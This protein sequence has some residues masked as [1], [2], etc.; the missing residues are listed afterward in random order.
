MSLLGV[1]ELG[2][3]LVNL[4][5]AG[6]LF[7]RGRKS[8]GGP[9][10][11]VFIL[12]TALWGFCLFAYDTRTFGAPE[13][14]LDWVFVT[15]YSVIGSVFL[16]SVTFPKKTQSSLVFPLVVYC[17]GL[18][19]TIYGFLFSNLFVAGVT[20][21]PE[22]TEAVMTK[23]YT[24]Y[25]IAAAA[26]AVFTFRNIAYSYMSTEGIT[27]LQLKYIL[28]ALLVEYLVIFTTDVF[29]PVVFGET[30][31]FGI[32]AASSL[33]FIAVVLYVMLRSRFMGI[34]FI[35]GKV[36]YFTSLLL[37]VLVFVVIGMLL[38]VYLFSGVG[39]TAVLVFLLLYSFACAV[40][41]LNVQDRIKEI[42]EARFVY[43]KFNPFSALA[44][45]S[46]KVNNLY[47]FQQILA[48]ASKVV[49]KA[50]APEYV[51]TMVFCR[52]LAKYTA[53]AVG[54]PPKRLLSAIKR[55]FPTFD[56]LSTHSQEPIIRDELAI[57]INGGKVEQVEVAKKTLSLMD[58]YGISVIIPFGEGVELKGL[59]CLGEL[60]D[61]Q[62]VTEEDVS[63]VHGLVQVLSVSLGRAMLY[64]ELLNFNESLKTEVNLA[65]G[66]LK[67]KVQQLKVAKERE[68]EI[69]EI[70]GHELKNPAAIAKLSI[71]SLIEQL[72]SG[73]VVGRRTLQD[74]LNYAFSAVD[75]QYRL[76]QRFLSAARL[77][78]GAF[79]TVP[80]MIDL[81]E[82][83]LQCL[84]SL[85]L[86]AKE[87]GLYLKL[88]SKKAVLINADKDALQQVIYNILDNAIK[89]T[90]SGGVSI[91]LRSD[92]NEVSCQI[93]DTGIGIQSEDEA[94]LGDRFFRASAVKVGKI[95]GSGLGLY[96]ASELLKAHHGRLEIVKNKPHGTIVTIYLP[97]V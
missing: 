96:V 85:K 79:Y 52:G 95:S 76:A 55:S 34:R 84:R 71:G 26:V 56:C 54:D 94:K 33:F 53:N 45:F 68:K 81:T 74:R 30:R 4:F 13:V 7:I 72:K 17:V 35:I 82:V 11:I 92:E 28:P 29:L 48:V 39:R 19:V 37:L 22:W 10:F 31:Y 43:V 3:V 16:F 36:L 18:V 86:V 1:I 91:A 78:K 46:S 5:F 8:P 6:L 87:K 57:S 51:F 42:I 93:A 2:T 27:K 59:I 50:F 24:W 65:T 12:S 15:S 41:F 67:R 69:V 49:A 47:D 77:A 70:M 73:G 62:V 61:R 75:R 25:S 80:E 83:V 23:Y 9:A 20:Q 60:K 14:W 44:N 64:N 32:S 21:M 63:F 89:Y 38:N 97:R 66:E 58:K 40:I 88:V 90:A